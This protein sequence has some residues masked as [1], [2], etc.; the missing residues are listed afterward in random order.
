MPDLEQLK[1]EMAAWRDRRLPAE[2][3]KL[4]RYERK[5]LAITANQPFSV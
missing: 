2:L 4:E 5:S 1:V 3:A